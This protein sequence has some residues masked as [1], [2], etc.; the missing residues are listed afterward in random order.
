MRKKLSVCSGLII[1]EI[2]AGLFRRKAF[3]DIYRFWTSLFDISILNLSF[4]MSRPFDLDY[5]SR[6]DR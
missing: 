6:I 5:L 2:Q 1:S 3:Y 4:Y